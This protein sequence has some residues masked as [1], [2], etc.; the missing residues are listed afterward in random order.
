MSVA[1]LLLSDKEA[2]KFNYVNDELDLIHYFARNRDFRRLKYLIVEKGV[3]VNKPDRAPMKET[4]LHHIFDKCIYYDI[5]ALRCIKLLVEHGADVNSRDRNRYT[6]FLKYSQLTKGFSNEIFE[7]LL[8]SGSDINAYERKGYTAISLAVWNST[9]EWIE[10]LLKVG[11]DPKHTV[12]SGR[13][14]LDILFYQK[15]KELMIR[16]PEFT[17]AKLLIEAGAP[18]PED[19]YRRS[20]YKSTPEQFYVLVSHINLNFIDIDDVSK[21]RY[22]DGLCSFE[23]VSFLKRCEKYGEDLV[24]KAIFGISVWRPSYL[25]FYPDS[26][27]ERVLELYCC[28][29]YSDEFWLP[30][31]I[32]DKIGGYVVHN[33]YLDYES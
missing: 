19:Y 18:V 16:S 23:K 27:K 5:P 31:D 22:N 4:P 10:P 13:T 21:L 24:N 8:E 6:P 32:L 9:V 25:C 20:V 7:Y 15:K 2:V 29:M 30:S 26:V 3:D 1:S 33:T 14:L 17:I 28:C 11:L 12:N